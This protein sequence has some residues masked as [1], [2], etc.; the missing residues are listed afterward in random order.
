MVVANSLALQPRPAR[1]GCPTG[2]TVRQPLPAS[3]VNRQRVASQF[4]E[5]RTRKRTGDR[6][7]MSTHELFE[8]VVGGI[9]RGDK[10]QAFGMSGHQIGLH[11][12]VI[13]GHNDALLAFGD[14]ND[15]GVICP[16]AAWQVEGMDRIVT[17]F[18]Q[19]G[20][21]SSWKL[22]IDEKLHAAKRSMR[23]TCARR[24]A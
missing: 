5:S 4:N 15:F 20:A 11:K 21:K 14:F 10:Q 22:C 7:Y 6:A 17:R 8:H 12:I 18:G 1:R 13:F 24:A 2:H 16:V 23:F 3:L 9:P 19:P